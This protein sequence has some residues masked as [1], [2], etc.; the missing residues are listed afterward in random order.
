MRTNTRTT[1]IVVAV[2]VAC[3]IGIW[4]YVSRDIDG[5]SAKMDIARTDTAQAGAEPGDL[6]ADKAT[7]ANTNTNTKTYSNPQ[8]RFSFDYPS[9]LRASAFTAPDGNGDVVVVAGNK[10]DDGFQILISAF[11]EQV[12]QLTAARIRK[13]VPDM[14]ILQ[15]QDVLLGTEGKGIAFM[16]GTDASTAKRQIWFVAGSRLYQITA[17]AIFDGR[18]KEIMA[19]WK[20]F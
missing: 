13:D 7:A 20:F 1:I 8:Y 17:P 3:A 15:P 12:N 5:Q 14:K 6:Q 10:P 19:T 9:E 2:V 18:L 4:A 11:D 16:D